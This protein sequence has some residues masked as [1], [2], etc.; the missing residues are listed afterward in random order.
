MELAPPKSKEI[1]AYLMSLPM[2]LEGWAHLDDITAM[3]AADLGKPVVSHIERYVR[4][5]VAEAQRGFIE[6][7]VTIRWTTNSRKFWTVS[8]ANLPYMNCSEVGNVLARTG[9]CR[10]DLV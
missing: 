7:S 9:E 2:T 8:V 1:N 4:E 5:A 6:A 3:D 10:P